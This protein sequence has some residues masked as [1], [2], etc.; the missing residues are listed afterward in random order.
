MHSAWYAA[1]LHVIGDGHIVAPHIVLPLAQAQHTAEHLARVHANSHVNVYARRLAHLTYDLDH[2]EAHLDAIVG[3]S[4][5]R[6]GQARDTVVAVAENF[7]SHAVVLLG[8]LVEFG[9]ELVENV[10]QL[11]R[12]KFLR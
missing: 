6:Y 2:L 10:D 1:G 3:V 8:F 9:E 4:R 12:L 7:Y 11:G 5:S